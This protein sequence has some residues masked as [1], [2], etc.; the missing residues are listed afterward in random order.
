MTQVDDVADAGQ[1]FSDTGQWYCWSCGR[2]RPEFLL[3]Q[4]S[5]IAGFVADTSQYF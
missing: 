1:Y 3:T 4:A 5:D 2:R